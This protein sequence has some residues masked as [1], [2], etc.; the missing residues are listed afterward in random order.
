LKGSVPQHLV[1]F[2]YM[3]IFI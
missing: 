3:R 1:N 2:G